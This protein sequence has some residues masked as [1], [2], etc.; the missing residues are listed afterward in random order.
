MFS[1]IT[2]EVFLTTVT[3]LAVSYYAIT[4]LLLYRKEIFQ[5]I[6]TSRNHS[7]ET[8]ST[9]NNDQPDSHAIIGSTRE[10]DTLSRTSSVNA[11]EVNVGAD[12]EEE[13]ETIK[14]FNVASAGKDNLLIG[15]VADLLQE[16]RTIFQLTTDY[17]S[18]KAECEAL[19]RTLLL[20]YPHVRKT[21]Y[22]QII[23]EYICE[24]GAK[25]FGF[26]IQL[27]EVGTWWEDAV[28]NRKDNPT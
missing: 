2:W 7:Q 26:P 28:P 15:S 12:D 1:T 18:E 3:L 11:E 10:Q 6:K 14:I 19:F 27:D 13:P 9:V 23:S 17:A 8:L 24:A 25:Q 16:V 5:H 21:A 20:R 4:T 22:R